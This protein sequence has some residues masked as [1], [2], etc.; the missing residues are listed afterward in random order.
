MLRKKCHCRTPCHCHHERPTIFEAI[1]KGRNEVPPNMSEA[2]GK[3]LALLSKDETRLDFIVQS[4]G[5][6]TPVISAYFYLAPSGVNGPVVKN[7]SIDSVGNGVGSW[8]S[9]I[10]DPSALTP[11]LVESL[12]EGDIYVNIHTTQYPAGEIRGQV[13]RFRN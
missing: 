1:L 13:I 8:T 9:T 4:G 12:K 3:M 5:Y 10:A 7:I 6:T 2:K 11:A